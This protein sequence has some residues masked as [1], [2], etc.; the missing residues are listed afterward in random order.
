[1]H[2]QLPQGQRNNFKKIKLK[3]KNHGL[4]DIGGV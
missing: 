4:G 3:I 1:M 2:L